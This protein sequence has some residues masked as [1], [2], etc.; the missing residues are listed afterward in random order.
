[1]LQIVQ[2]ALVWFSAVGCAVIGGVYFAFSTFAMTAFARLDRAAGIA[3]MQAINEVILHSLFMPLFF[4]T[5][6]ATATVA[7]LA[8]LNWSAPS[9]LI[10]FLAGL[11]FVLGMFGVTAGFNV[12]M[13]N[14]LA[15]VDAGSAELVWANYIADWTWWNHVRTVA[16]I[17]A[18][19]MFIVALVRR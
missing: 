6:I 18:S 16:S 5:T 15:V 10:I 7:V 3:A 1:M 14:A 12:P 11:I 9:S 19:L 4:G 2:T 8:I 17:G 13:N